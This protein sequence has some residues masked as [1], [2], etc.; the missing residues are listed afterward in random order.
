MIFMTCSYFVKYQTTFSSDPNP[1]ALVLRSANSLKKELLSN[2][3]SLLLMFYSLY[4]NTMYI[5]SLIDEYILSHF[6]FLLPTFSLFSE[7]LLQV[8]RLNFPCGCTHDGCANSN[9]RIEFNPMRVRTHFIHTMMRIEM[10][11]KQEQEEE[12]RRQELT[13][14]GFQTYHRQDVPTYSNYHFDGGFS[15][16]SYPYQP[17][18]T[19]HFQQY[20]AFQTNFRLE[21][22]LN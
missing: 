17:Y 22:I 13:A 6:S 11:K 15:Y 20:D 14:G 12:A 7:I 21:I 5:H 1:A 19:S 3:L 4:L 18:D 9:G 2:K 10:E 8:D 16:P